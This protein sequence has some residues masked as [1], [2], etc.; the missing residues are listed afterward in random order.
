M[1]W[2]NFLHIYQPPIQS[3]VMT[4][5][6]TKE[7][8]SRISEILNEN[9]EA[10]ITLNINASLSEQLHDFGYD[11]LLES[12]NELAKRGQIEF[13]SSGAYHP[14]LPLIPKNEMKRQI[15]Q[16]KIKN[17]KLIGNAYKPTGIWPPEMC[18]TKEVAEVC[19]ELGY[20]WLILD[21]IAATV[22]VYPLARIFRIKGMNKGLDKMDNNIDNKDLNKELQKEEIHK[23]LEFKVFFRARTPSNEISFADLNRVSDFICVLNRYPDFSTLITATDGEVYGHHKKNLD[24]LWSKLLSEKRFQTITISEIEKNYG[25][26]SEIEPLACSWATTEEDLGRANPFPQWLNKYNIIHKKQWI[27][28]ELVIDLV[29]EY[30]GR[31]LPHEEGSNARQILDK[32]LFS[33]Q[34][35]WANRGSLWLPDFVI[36]G[37]D[38]FL[39]SVNMTTV[40]QGR[41]EVRLIYNLANDIKRMVST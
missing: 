35:Y 12:Y 22:P 38:L 27:L 1:L 17:E 31:C 16:N 37:V 21:E 39:Q 14:I 9:P 10:K 4:E 19:A 26:T 15:V 5:R 40:P 18:Y 7:C 6:I 20:K 25:Y 30:E 28:T 33:C 41:P 2:A 11:K 13:T 8:Y 34:Y 29:N 3:R 36:K 32:A 23:G 24:T